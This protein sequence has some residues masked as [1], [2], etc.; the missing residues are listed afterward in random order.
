MK[1]SFK[2]IFIISIGMGVIISSCTMSKKL[3]ASNAQVVSLKKDSIE[4]HQKLSNATATKPQLAEENAVLIAPSPQLNNSKESTLIP[5]LYVKNEFRKDYP[6]VTD[7]VW[8]KENS[9]KKSA[10]T[11]SLY[12]TAIFVV[13]KKMNWVRYST[14]GTILET[15]TEILPDQLP[16]SIQ[17]SIRKLYP[18]M[19]II[20]ATTYKNI[21]NKGTYTVVIKST[22]NAMDKE[23]ILMDDGTIIK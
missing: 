22:P 7:E 9:I 12:Y 19:R 6:F 14:N 21:D 1:T 20:S 15:R 10:S 17:K 18:E 3:Q 23:L 5:S 4:T 13:N 8:A 11:D 16:A 2:G